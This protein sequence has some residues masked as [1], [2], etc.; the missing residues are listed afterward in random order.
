MRPRFSVLTTVFNPPPEALR[1]CLASVRRQTTTDWQHVVVNDGSDEATT[2]LLRSLRHEQMVLVEG[3]RHGIVG[4]ARRA[5]E[6]ASGDMVALL[7]HDDMLHREA[8]AQAGAHLDA[9]PAHGV[10]YTDHDIIRADGRRTEPFLKPDFSPERLRSQNYITHLVVARRALVDEVGGFRDGFDGAQDHDLLLRLS[11]HAAIGH[12]AEVLYH[13]RQA[14][15]S[16]AS[17]ASN[18]TYAYDA[19]RRAVHEHCQRV[20]IDAEVLN[21]AELGCYRLRR[22]SDLSAHVLIRSTGKT[23]VVWGAERTF[24]D[25]AAHMLRSAGWPVDVVT[26]VPDHVDADVAVVVDETTEPT[27]ADAVAELVTLLSQPDVAMVGGRLLGSDG[28]IRSGGI[29]GDPPADALR[30]WAGGHPGPGRLMLV[31]REVAAVRS[32]V[33]AVRAADLASVAAHLNGGRSITADVRMCAELRTTGRRVLWTPRSSWY[34]FDESH[35]ASAAVGMP[36][37]YYPNTM[38]QGR[39]DWLEQPGLAGAPPYYVDGGG[40]KRFV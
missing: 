1:E 25:A 35:D 30:G 10:V 6:A 20:G 4:A 24:A 40:T 8:L 39:G 36:D 29:V 17:D 26:E 23:G 12:V 37:P 27:H 34:W 28:R 7:D 5:L 9:H 2:K 18:K 22:C 19:G 33:C 21:G 38:V 16:V 31:D 3:G 15:D 14:P 32:A 13:W 11:E